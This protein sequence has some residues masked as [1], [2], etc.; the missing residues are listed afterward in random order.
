MVRLV[1]VRTSIDAEEYAHVFVREIFA[2]H[3]LPASIVSDRDPRFTSEFFQQL[4]KLLDIKQRMSTAFHPQTDGQTERMNRTLEEML[5][6]FV[7]PSLND[8]DIH[9]PCCEFAM[10]NA[11]NESIRATPFYLNYGRHPKSPTDFA[12]KSPV[13][14]SESFPAKMKESLERAKDCMRIAQERQSRYASKKRRDLEF[15]VGDI[16]MLDSKNLKLKME[17]AHKLGHRFIGPYKILKRVG[18]VSYELELTK[19]MRIHDVF[20][21]SLLRPYHK[22]EGDSEGAPP[23]LMPSGDIHHEVEAVLNHVDDLDNI[24]W[25]EV[26][27]ADNDISWI[28]RAMLHT[29]GRE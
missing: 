17:G 18:P 25:Y 28:T 19:D 4:C 29:V 22:R 10:N 13:E 24:R 3:G 15:Q 26:K 23:A 14:P 7:R 16:V 20:H 9:L 11:F 5:R 6:S 8:W 1:P 21:V 27:W 2:K 12:F